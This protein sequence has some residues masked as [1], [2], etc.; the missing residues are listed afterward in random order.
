MTIRSVRIARCIP[1]ATNANSQYVTVF[2][3][4]LQQLHERASVLRYKYSACLVPG[5]NQL[6]PS[7]ILQHVHFIRN[8]YL[9][10]SVRFGIL[11]LW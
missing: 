1:N 8:L 3:F 6:S 4:P 11:R 9:S 5:E 10:L 7:I 2:V